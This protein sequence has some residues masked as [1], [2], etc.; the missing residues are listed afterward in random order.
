M[1]NNI[2]LFFLFVLVSSIAGQQEDALALSSKGEYLKL[3]SIESK[4]LK[5]SDIAALNNLTVPFIPNRNQ[6]N[7]EVAY[8]A[9][10]SDGTVFVNKSGEIVYSLRQNTLPVLDRK[11]LQHLPQYPKGTLQQPV[12][13]SERFL[14]SQKQTITPGMESETTVSIFH[15]NDQTKWENELP[16]YAD[17]SLGKIYPGIELRLSAH[18]RSVEKLFAVDP[19]ANPENIEIQIPVAEKLSLTSEGQLLV[20][21]KTGE[22]QF[23]RP[24]AWQDIDGNRI[25]VDIAYSLGNHNNTYGFQIGGYNTHHPLFIDPLLQSTY[26]GGNANDLGQEIAIAPNGD[27]YVGGW[28]ESNPFPLCSG[29]MC[30]Y[31]ADKTF[32][33]ND[34]LFVARISPDLKRLIQTTYLGGTCTSSQWYAETFDGIAIAANGDVFV[35]GST[36]ADDFPGITGGADTV[37]GGDDGFVTKFSSDLRTLSQ[38]T[39]VGGTNGDYPHDIAI[40]DSTQ[41]V[42][43]GLTGSPDFPVCA[44]STALCSPSLRGDTVYAGLNEAFVAILTTDLKSMPYTT[45]LGGSANEYANSVLVAN[46]SIYVAG[47]T[48]SSDFPGITGGFDVTLQGGEAFVTQLSS[49][50]HSITQSTFFGGSGSEEGNAIAKGANGSIY[51]AGVTT[52]SDI[53]RCAS[54]LCPLRADETQN[55]TEGFV[56]HCSSDLKNLYNSTYLGG[57]NF[58]YIYDLTVSP[59]P[60]NAWHPDIVYVVGETMSNDFPGVGKGADRTYSGFNEGFAVRLNSELSEIEQGTYLGGNGSDVANSIAVASNG[61]I[62][63]AGETSS[64]NFPKITGGFDTTLSGYDAFISRFSDLKNGGSY[65]VIPHSNDKAAVIFLQ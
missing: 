20:G 54:G 62:Y 41:I 37:R 15:G 50:L 58:D 12:V 6:L 11:N 29:T 56:V 21:T 60:E 26:L 40:L 53:P 38:S 9:K 31:G 44:S 32:Q 22:A 49:T 42:I 39:F 65:Y 52:S 35:T 28:T 55:G 16:T 1:K 45:F 18:S 3:A 63:I 64:A 13:F 27:I 61:E 46:G 24:V 30:A 47:S 51:I 10:V 23:S 59:D 33:S 8:Y 57:S 4:S 48:G 25:G 7:Q 2:R 14:N 43:A 36:C 5:P 19:G 34:E 17:V